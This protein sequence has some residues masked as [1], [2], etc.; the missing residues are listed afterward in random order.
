MKKKNGIVLRP[1]NYLIIVLLSVTSL[2]SP[3][4]LSSETTKDWLVL[5]H[6]AAEI[7]DAIGGISTPFIGFLAAYLVYLSFEAQIEANQTQMDII[8]Q[9]MKYNFIT[10]LSNEFMDS[11]DY[12]KFNYQ[13]RDII[14]NSICS[15]L[16]NIGK[17]LK[18]YEVNKNLNLSDHNLT[19][20]EGNFLGCLNTLSMYVQK[21]VL[22]KEEISKSNLPDSIKELKKNIILNFVK[23]NITTY[24]NRTRHEYYDYFSPEMKCEI[25]EFLSVTD[26]LNR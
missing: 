13:G 11:F 12:L 10:S 5:G 2:I 9:D 20:M 24:I 18:T 7:G 23:D 14:G 3:I 17:Q 8:S 22:I 16:N 26:E 21:F 4:L 15:S 1:M 19:Q 6:S 25:K